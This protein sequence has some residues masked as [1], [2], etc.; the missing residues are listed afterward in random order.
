LAANCHEMRLGRSHD[1]II[2]GI[3]CS[4]PYEYDHR[5]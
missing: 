5:G 3:L 1:S 2:S 4:A